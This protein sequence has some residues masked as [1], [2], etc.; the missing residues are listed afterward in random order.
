[1]I[2]K[3]IIYGGHILTLNENQ[4]SVE[5]V[6]IEGEKISAVGNLTDVKNN[7]GND[8]ELI[9]LNGST[10]LPG[11]IDS[12][13]HPIMLIFFLINVN[14]SKVKSIKDLQ[15]VL[16]EA[17]SQ[18]SPSEWIIGLRLKEE[19]FINPEERTLPTRWQLDE[20]C[21]EN[22][23][24]LV[25]YDGHIGIANTKALEIAGINADTEVPEGGEIRKNENGEVTGIIS[26]E[27][28]NLL[29]S[30]I[31]FPKPPEFMEGAEKAFKILAEKGITSIHGLVEYDRGRGIEFSV[32]KSIM[33][34]VLQNWYC[35]VN[36]ENTENI[37]KVKKPPLDE[38][39][40]YSKFKI[41]GLKTF[42]DGTFGAKT[43]CM[44]EPFSDAPNMCG[45][46]VVDIEKLYNQMKGAHNLGFQIGV[47]TI[48]DKGNRIVVD[49]YKRLLKENPRKDHRHRIEH[50]SMLTADVISDMK[51]LNLIASC[52]PSFIN[53]EYTWL[54]KRI[55][56]E[57]CKYTYP[58][59]SL[60]D[61]GVLIASGSDCPVEEPDVF[62][63][64]H[65]LVTRNGLVPEECIS[66]KEALKTYTINGAYAAFEEDVKGSIEVG[67]L[68]DF[69]I[70]DKNPMEVP[71][72]KI[73]DIQVLKT[74]IRGKN[75]YKRN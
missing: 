62:M 57:R 3:K 11:F 16:K 4:S 63:G 69:V 44:F 46:C 28:L 52:Q 40:K 65:A 27:A 20:M 67:K 32:M 64:L 75:V 22:P 2:E 13:I 37:I 38:G 33:D 19:E 10:L 29:F 51:E 60:I 41:G 72:D 56:K 36:T 35:L 39:H 1:L 6:A 59:K 73:K 17:A 71:K 70:L 9:N 23:V 34:K 18:K 5:A 24:F 58:Y 30:K 68:A 7:M 43:A 42:V 21:S 26:E 53:S 31:S 66:I 14:L 49:L 45:F 50:A 8:F 55:G 48:G 47:H 54:E 25:R 12:H 61:A 74:I 15:T